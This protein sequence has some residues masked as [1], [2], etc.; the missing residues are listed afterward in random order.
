M[1]QGL[2]QVDRFVTPQNP[3]CTVSGAIN[4]AKSNCCN[5]VPVSHTHSIICAQNVISNARKSHALIKLNVYVHHVFFVIYI[6]S[7]GQLIGGQNGG[8]D[9]QAVNTWG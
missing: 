2:L 3:F 8:F 1:P 7:S 5:Y 6:T 4:R 9:T